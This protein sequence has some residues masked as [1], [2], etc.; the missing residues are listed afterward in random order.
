M[1]KKL[2]AATFIGIASIFSA[3]TANAQ[4]AEV[5]LS[6]GAYTQM[7]AMNMH[8]GW[9]GVNTAWGAL[10]AGV[11]FKL[12]IKYGLARRTHSH[13]QLPKAARNTPASHTTP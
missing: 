13:Q 12:P 6:Y 9:E 8:D 7:D 10:N 1:I 5:T 4:K 11:N 3:S 2:I